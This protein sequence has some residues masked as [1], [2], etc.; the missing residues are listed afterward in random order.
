MVQ[1]PDKKISFVNLRLCLAKVT[2]GFEK[3]HF[4]IFCNVGNDGKM[5]PSFRLEP[6]SIFS[7]VAW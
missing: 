6:Y 7:Y 3:L 1:T 4:T 5:V 2:L